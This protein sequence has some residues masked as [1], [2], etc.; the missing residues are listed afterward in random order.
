MSHYSIFDI[1]IDYAII[2]IDIDDAIRLRHAI[3]SAASQA[4]Y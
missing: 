4:D 1:I 2:I 3:I